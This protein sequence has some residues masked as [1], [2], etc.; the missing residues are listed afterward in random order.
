MAKTW[1]Y[2]KTVKM[3]H[4]QRL[5]IVD[6][7]TGEMIDLNAESNTVAI[8]YGKFFIINERALATIFE[9]KLINQKDKAYILDMAQMLKTEYNALYTKQNTP[10]TLETLSNIFDLHYDRC[11]TLMKKLTKNGIVGRLSTNGKTF[12]VM[13][14]YLVKS[15]KYIS[16]ETSDIFPDF[17]N[18]QKRK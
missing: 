10:H 4:N 11:T 13:N 6:D 1:D 7:E 5:L 9:M 18:L 14:P 3:K 2:E 12:Y 16:T 8:N 17:E 15:R